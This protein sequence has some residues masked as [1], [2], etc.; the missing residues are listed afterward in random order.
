[1]I[2]NVK[3]SYFLGIVFSLLHAGALAIL[4]VIDVPVWLRVIIAAALLASL[5]RTLMLHTLRRG[6]GAVTALRLLSDG[7]LLVRTPRGKSWQHA[8]ISARFVH[9]KLVLL[10]TQWKGRHFGGA[11]MVPADAVDREAFRRLR[12]R[13]LAPPRKPAV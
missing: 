12:A 3:V 13:L 10:R 11:V 5:Y 8:A 7:T 9:P 2:I 4:F 1:M 6:A